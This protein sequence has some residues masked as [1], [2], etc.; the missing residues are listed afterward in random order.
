MTHETSSHTPSIP[1]GIYRVNGEYE[2]EEEND[3]L[4]TVKYDTVYQSRFDDQPIAQAPFISKYYLDSTSIID[5][6][7]RQSLPNS[8][9]NLHL[10]SYY[11]PLAKTRY[12]RLTRHSQPIKQ[13]NTK[14][15]PRDLNCMDY[16]ILVNKIISDR[17]SNSIRTDVEYHLEQSDLQTIGKGQFGVV[18]SVK[19]KN[20]AV[21]SLV[22]EKV[23]NKDAWEDIFKEYDIWSEIQSKLKSNSHVAKI[24]GL[25][26]FLNQASERVVGIVMQLYNFEL[27]IYIKNLIKKSRFNKEAILKISWQLIESVKQLHDVDV[28]HGDIAMRNFLVDDA[29]RIYVTDF[30]LSHKLER[31]K[32]SFSTGNSALE[33]SEYYSVTDIKP[34]PF[35]WCAPEVVEKMLHRKPLIL[36]KKSDIYMLGCTMAEVMMMEHVVEKSLKS[37]IPFSYDHDHNDNLLNYQTEIQI[38]KSLSLKKSTTLQFSKND[39]PELSIYVNSCTDP[40]SVTRPEIKML[41]TSLGGLIRK[42]DSQWIEKIEITTTIEDGFKNMV[43]ASCSN[44]LKNICFHEEFSEEFEENTPTDSDQVFVYTKTDNSIPIYGNSSPFQS[45][46]QQSQIKTPLSRSPNNNPFPV[47]VPHFR[48]SK[49]L[50]KNLSDASTLSGQSI[51]DAYIEKELDEIQRRRKISEIGVPRSNAVVNRKISPPQTKNKLLPDLLKQ[52]FVDPVL[53]LITDKNSKIS[54][55]SEF[56]D[57]SNGDNLNTKQ[58][59]ITIE[60]TPIE[61][62]EMRRLSNSSGS[63]PPERPPPERPPPERPP[64]PIN[65]KSVKPIVAPKP[66]LRPPLPNSRSRPISD[67]ILGINEKHSDETIQKTN[68]DRTERKPQDIQSSFVESITPELAKVLEKQRLKT[69]RLNKTE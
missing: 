23:W 26:T 48:L 68:S 50:E 17:E 14:S 22:E 40:N 1:T 31:K 64:P 27:K 6:K 18:Y 54:K 28:I 58:P 47:T 57:Q 56:Q 30:G 43:S 24:Y 29:E 2:E 52:T 21:K 32:Q 33:Y 45:K 60:K 9:K 25:A 16:N 53:D 37:Y 3:E 63:K 7:S 42:F 59:R 49:K 5:S 34:L 8:R 4:Q 65:L 44:S 41:Q 69:E 11:T 39:C 19:N 62:L 61:L 10:T 38:K 12:T 36:T 13:S 51:D 55:N 20:L 46:S 67:S 35:W 15:E 66:K